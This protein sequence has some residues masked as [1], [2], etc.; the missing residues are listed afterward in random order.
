MQTLCQN[1]KE[2][3]SRSRFYFTLYKEDA[4]NQTFAFFYSNIVIKPF[5]NIRSWEATNGVG[6]HVDSLYD[7][8]M[9]SAADELRTHVRALCIRFRSWTVAVIFVV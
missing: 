6:G 7:F 1:H 2:T 4:A 8:L 3:I 9:C 5:L